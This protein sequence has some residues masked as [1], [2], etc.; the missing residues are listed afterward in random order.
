MDVLHEYSCGALTALAHKAVY[1]F[2]QLKQFIEA[3]MTSRRKNETT[4][5]APST[6]SSRTVSHRSKAASHRSKAGA[7]RRTAPSNLDTTEKNVAPSQWGRR[8][9]RL[10][11]AKFGVQMSPNHSKNEGTWKRRDIV[12]KCAKSTMPP[13]SVLIDMLERIDELWAVYL[14][15][16][17]EA[18]V[19]SVPARE[20]RRLGYYTRGENVQKRV[21]LSRRKLLPVAKLIGTM[22]RE[23]VESCRIP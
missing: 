15:S 22:T 1:S 6:T 20:V 9:A 17:G 11:G 16:E 19:W 8:L 12:I 14:T 18:E 2:Q 3:P 5:F 10:V 23:E 7:S 13:V 4:S 21:E